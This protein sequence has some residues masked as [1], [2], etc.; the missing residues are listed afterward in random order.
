MS[1]I[2]EVDEVIYAYEILKKDHHVYNLGYLRDVLLSDNYV[3]L[4]EQSS[5]E[6]ADTTYLLSKRFFDG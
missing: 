4:D 3:W 1:I 6:L 2:S 5:T